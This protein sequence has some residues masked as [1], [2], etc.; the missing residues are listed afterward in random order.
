MLPAEKNAQAQPVMQLILDEARRRTLRLI[1][2]PEGESLDLQVVEDKPYGAAN[3]YLGNYRSR[4]ELNI[5]RPMNLF[6]LVYQMAHEGYPGHHAEFSIK[7][8]G[9]YRATGCVEQ[10]LSLIGPQLVISEGL[11]L[12]ASEIIFSAQE[13][14]DWAAEHLL[15]LVELDPT[16]VDLLRLIEGSRSFMLD[17]IGSN[18]ELLLESGQSQ[19]QALDYALA[20]TPY[21][22]ELLEKFCSFSKSP[23]MRIYTFAYSQGKKL[24]RPLMQSER[25]KEYLCRLLS[26]QTVPEDVRAWGQSGVDAT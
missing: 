13:L 25:C 21:S 17:D 23:L 1:D 14:A 3:W 6:G 19:A 11:A 24:L 4:L 20:Y 18:L 10:S 9:I 16:E 7:E 5:S 8:S 22:F 15:P 26:E 12:L 2:L